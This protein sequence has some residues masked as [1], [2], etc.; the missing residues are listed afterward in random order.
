VNE[1]IENVF[2]KFIEGA[3]FRGREYWFDV[4]AAVLVLR[5]AKLQQFSLLGFD[6]GIL[7]ADFTQ[8]SMEF[9]KDYTTGNGRAVA[10]RYAD[11]I[12]YISAKSNTGLRFSLVF[13]EKNQL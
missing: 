8:P 2:R 6:A 12:E 10:D 3:I 4:D 7:G 11:A 9:S 13:S 5:E 1:R